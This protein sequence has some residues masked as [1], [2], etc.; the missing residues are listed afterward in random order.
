MTIIDW[1]YFPF[2]EEGKLDVELDFSV[3][4]AEQYGIDPRE[5]LDVYVASFPFS[6]RIS[7][8][9]QSNNIT[10]V[11][12]LLEKTPRDLMQISGFGWTCLSE[13]DKFFSMVQ[14][15][16]M[17]QS[18]KKVQISSDI[19]CRYIYRI[20]QGDFTFLDEEI[21]S[22]KD[23]EAISRIQQAYDTLGTD[24][25]NKCLTNPISVRNIVLMFQKFNC[26][27]NRASEI[28][29]LMKRIPNYRL[30]NLA[31]GYINAFTQ[32]EEIRKLLLS[33]YTSEHSVLGQLI[34]NRLDDEAVYIQTKK[35]LKWC[36]F[37]LYEDVATIMSA[38]TGQG[39]RQAVIEM[40]ARKFTLEKCGNKLNITRERVRQIEA[41]AVRYFAKY[42]SSINL[43]AKI[44][45]EKNGYEIITP[46]DVERYGGEQSA[47]LLFLLRNCKSGTYTYDEQLDVFI[48]GDNTLHDRVYA[49]VEDLPEMFSVKKLPVYLEIAKEE[50][51]LPLSAVE[52]AIS[53]AYNFTGEVYHRSRLTLASVYSAILREHYPNGIKAY[54]TDE[55][56]RFR[57]LVFE[58]YGNVKMPENDHALTA[59]ITSVCVLCGRGTYKLKQKDYIPKDLAK[60]IY[61]YIVNGDDSIYLMNTLFSV[62][63]TELRKYGVDNK[64]FLQGILHE[65]YGDKLIFT[66]DYVSTDEGETSIYASVVAFIKQSRYPVSKAQIQEK[67]PGITDV[68][69]SFSV[70]DPN[71]LNYFGEYLHTSRLRVSPEEER[72]LDKTI[73]QVCMDGVSH[74]IKEFYEIINHEKPEILTRNAAL[75]PFSAFSVL[76]YLFRDVY[77]F[78]R[79]YIA[80][81]G[82]EIGRP[83][84]RL[85][86]FLY[87]MEEFS[88]DDISDFIKE[89]HFQIQ[90]QLD[91]VNSCN[92]KYLIV[93]G[94]MI[95]SI[96]SIGVNA[97][98]AAVVE[99]VVAEE[100]TETM[101][102]CQLTC[103]ASFPAIKIPWTE[104]LV[105]SVLNKWS[106]QLS[107]APSSNQFRLSVPLVAPVGK[108]DVAPY[109]EAYKNARQTSASSNS[110]PDDLENIDDLLA[111]MLDDELLE[112]NVWG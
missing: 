26:I 31:W 92:D 81:D 65:L 112:D 94:A 93:D 90:S 83:G 27:E 2:F 107:V 64:Y 63:E 44:S 77:Q 36:A 78:S 54:D 46:A 22:D 1:R 33:Q 72:Y 74:H 70:G 43:I 18:V 11:A 21:L 97:E 48:I 98:I 80:M 25:V 47:E 51:D 105:Y 89:N 4:F 100:V 95:K 55:I 102:I 108:M 101:P 85:H 52:M 28:D 82:V 86:E 84:E 40:R 109:S 20:L 9:L 110:V 104:W 34:E 69:I 3:T 103:W 35:F 68:V 61:N 76:E 49:F 41:K 8:R 24:L 66:R 67:F 42:Q 53:E 38:V 29:E 59:R 10:T 12:E 30:Q 5:Y 37:D 23:K 106:T 39:K 57:E 91:Y 73:R 88:F 99:R 87:G 19:I 60:R 6:V 75:Y 71:V 62:F 16:V 56:S 45:A 58:T 17:S 79:P 50:N 111:E 32:D 14:E 15:G 13:I 96:D 7:N